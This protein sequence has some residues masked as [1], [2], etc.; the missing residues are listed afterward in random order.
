MGKKSESKPKGAGC[1]VDYGSVLGNYSEPNLHSG[2]IPACRIYKYYVTLQEIIDMFQFKNQETLDEFCKKRG[3]TYRKEKFHESFLI[4]NT[5]IPKLKKETSKVSVEEMKAYF[6]TK[7]PNGY[8]YSNSL[9]LDNKELLE[10]YPV[11]VRKTAKILEMDEHL[12]TLLKREY[13]FLPVWVIKFLVNTVKFLYVGKDMKMRPSTEKAHILQFLRR[14]FVPLLESYREN[15]KLESANRRL[16]LEN[17]K[18]KII[19]DHLSLKIDEMALATINVTNAQSE[20]HSML[21]NM[22]HWAMPYFDIIMEK[23]QGILSYNETF[24]LKKKIQGESSENLARELNTTVSVVNEYFSQGLR[25]FNNIMDKL[26]K[27]RKI[28]EQT[29]DMVDGFYINRKE[30]C[31]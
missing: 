31:R 17:E 5:V 16:M 11:E 22:R 30:A 4:R 23:H 8:Y 14:N 6:K 12:E 26:N 29:K 25:K 21:E 28:K 19:N 3:V 27:S 18:L 15:Q 24:C 10:L 1:I 13:T 2:Y 7:L 9:Y 20:N